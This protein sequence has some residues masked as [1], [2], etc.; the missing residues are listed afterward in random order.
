MFNYKPGLNIFLI[1]YLY[2]LMFFY[3]YVLFKKN[4]F[5]YLVCSRS[6]FGFLRDVPVLILSKLGFRL[7]IHVHGSD[8]INLFENKFIRE[9][10]KNLY[11]NCEIIV[12][13][14]HMLDI[15]KK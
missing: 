9:I 12:P 15:L 14:K 1:V 10:A 7:I 2:K 5:I 8:F 11:R 6:F 3:L 4:K 13:S